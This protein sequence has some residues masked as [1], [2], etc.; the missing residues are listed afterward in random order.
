MRCCVQC[1]ALALRYHVLDHVFI[2]RTAIVV[3]GFLPVSICRASSGEPG[4]DVPCLCFGCTALHVLPSKL[5]KDGQ[6]GPDPQAHMLDTTRA[7]EGSCIRT[8]R[9]D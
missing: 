8:V 2:H 5:T 1:T 3:L 7:A 9:P 4:P 6:L